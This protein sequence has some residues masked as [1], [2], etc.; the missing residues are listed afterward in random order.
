MCNVANVIKRTEKRVQLRQKCFSHANANCVCLCHRSHL[1]FWPVPQLPAADPK[2]LSK[3]W[4]RS[5][6]MNGLKQFDGRRG[7][8][9]GQ[10]TP[11]FH[12]QS[13]SLPQQCVVDWVAK[14]RM[15]IASRLFMWTRDGAGCGNYYNGVSYSGH[16]ALVTF[17]W[18]W[19]SDRI[20][21]L[22]SLHGVLAPPATLRRKWVIASRSGRVACTSL[23]ERAINNWSLL[24]N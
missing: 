1:R 14:C 10:R 3:R 21:Q 20:S 19:A 9:L 7:L 18:I 11:H 5:H 23:I 17:V 6:D 2:A 15:S 13:S 8:G 12:T 16:G 4:K 24:E 22:S